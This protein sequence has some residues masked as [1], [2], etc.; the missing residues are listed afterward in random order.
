MPEN[1]GYYQK[2]NVTR[3]DEKPIEG[4]TWTLEVDRDPFAI[5]A[6]RAYR[7]AADAAGGFEELVAALDAI[8]REIE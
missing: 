4:R 3:I 6:L 5:P 7:D 2:Y 8:L 1:T